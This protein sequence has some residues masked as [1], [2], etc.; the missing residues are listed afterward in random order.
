ME[1]MAYYLVVHMG[2]EVFELGSVGRS[3]DNTSE[4]PWRVTLNFCGHMT[5]FKIDSGAD[6]CV[7]SKAEFSRLNPSHV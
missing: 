1:V 7:I 3:N 5:A 6:V 4:P 2:P